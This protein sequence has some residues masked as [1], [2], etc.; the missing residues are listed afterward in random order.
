MSR[1]YTQKPGR[2][3]STWDDLLTAAAICEGVV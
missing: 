2:P 1:L 3:D